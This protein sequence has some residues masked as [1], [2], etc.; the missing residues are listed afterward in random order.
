M[1]RVAPSEEQVGWARLSQCSLS[2]I[3][4]Q[5]SSAPHGVSCPKCSAREAGP[6]RSVTR[7]PAEPLG[8]T[9]RS[10][11]GISPEWLDPARRRVRRRSGTPWLAGVTAPA[12]GQL[13]FAAIA[14]GGLTSRSARE[15]S[16]SL[17]VRRTTPPSPDPCS[18]RR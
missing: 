2:L 8:S 10:R 11:E 5:K 17:L 12:D 3:Q 13:A 7:F 4:N 14:I 16:S 15:T 6:P 1:E 18:A 9:G